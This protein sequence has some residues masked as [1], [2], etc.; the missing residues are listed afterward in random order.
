[1]LTYH[2][3]A[4]YY[5]TAKTFHTCTGS[6][7]DCGVLTGGSTT[8]LAQG[9]FHNSRFH[10][11]LRA[12]APPIVAYDRCIVGDAVYQD[13]FRQHFGLCLAS[14]ASFRELLLEQLHPFESYIELHVGDILDQ[15]WR[16][17]EFIEVLCLDVCKH[18]DITRHLATSFFPHLEPSR[19]VVLQQDYSSGWQPHIVYLM[20][21]LSDCFEKVL[22]VD[23]LAIF[24]CTAPVVA[25]VVE[26]TWHHYADEPARRLSLM[27]QAIEKAQTP[28]TRWFLMLARAR[29]MGE[30]GL[31]KDALG[32]LGDIDRDADEQVRGLAT[33][34]TN[35]G[36]EL[37]KL[38]GELKATTG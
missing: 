26:A 2:E 9:L 32:Y 14:G 24:R 18:P 4:A 27:D 20:E 36:S 19:S 37:D 10:E 30:L 31:I 34:Q 3:R 29:L 35:F 6:I 17:E 33:Y 23:D 21:M 16:R 8:A 15:F 38:V 7:V 22:E 25:E 13:Y 12:Q 11:E 28:D 1:M 5:L